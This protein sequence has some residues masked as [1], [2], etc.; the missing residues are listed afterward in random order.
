M[1]KAFAVVLEVFSAILFGMLIGNVSLELV[2]WI[3]LALV[4]LLMMTEIFLHLAEKRR[5]ILIGIV[6]VLLVA[7]IIPHIGAAFDEVALANY[8]PIIVLGIL[9][10][11][12]GAKIAVFIGGVIR[13]KARAKKIKELEKQAKEQEKETE[14]AE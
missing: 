8:T 9:I 5:P 11:I 3:T 13:E 12:L 10:L 1:K 2:D 14:A 4:S 6:N 7:A